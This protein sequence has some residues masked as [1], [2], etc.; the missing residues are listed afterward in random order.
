VHA[1][2][3][4]P[5]AILDVGAIPSCLEVSLTRDH[6][7]QAK[8]GPFDESR[9]LARPRF[10]YVFRGTIFVPR[11]HTFCENSPRLNDGCHNDLKVT[12]SM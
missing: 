11:T 9:R 7:R 5:R 4:W 10:S 2:D 1:S 6:V 12:A 8:K 3:R